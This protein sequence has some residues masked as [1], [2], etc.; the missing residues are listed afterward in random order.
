MVAT[1]HLADSVWCVKLCLAAAPAAHRALSATPLRHVRICVP[2]LSPLWYPFTVYSAPHND[3]TIRILFRQY[4]SFTW[5]VAARLCEARRPVVLVDGYHGNTGRLGAAMQHNAIIL[6][7]GA[8]AFYG[9]RVTYR[10]TALQS[11]ENLWWSMLPIPAVLG[12]ALTVSVPAVVLQEHCRVRGARRRTPVCRG[13]GPRRQRVSSLLR[14]GAPANGSS[15]A[16]WLVYE[17]AF[18]V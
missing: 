13:R 12:V 5:G 10:L 17:E 8:I 14:G 15:T 3:A 18:E 11:S 1:T 6:V 9:L 4:G 2:E 7:A 16:T